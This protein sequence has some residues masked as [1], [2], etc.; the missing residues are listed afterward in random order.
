MLPYP[1]TS[2]GNDACPNTPAGET[3]GLNGCSSTQLGI[4]SNTIPADA[5][6]AYPNPTKGFFEIALPL[7]IQETTIE[8]YT[9]QMQSISKK[10]YPVN[11]GKVKLSIENQASGVYFTKVGLESPLTL[12]IIKQ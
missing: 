5:V 12:K 9:L 11:N 1:T 8:L 2:L 3:V 7:S 10:S 6:R 4:A